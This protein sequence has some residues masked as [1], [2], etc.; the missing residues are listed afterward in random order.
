VNGMDLIREQISAVEKRIKRLGERSQEIGQIVSLISTMSE[1]THAL[2]LNASM[3]AAMAG[4]A[5]RGFAVVAEEVQRLSESARTST[6]QIAQLVQNI[7]VE[8]NDT[9]HTMNKAIEQVVAGS[10]AAAE[11]GER[12]HDTQETTARLVDLVQQINAGA[13]AQESITDILRKRV[14]DIGVST[15]QTA[16]Q[17]EVQNRSADLL[18][19]SARHLVA[20]VSVFKLPA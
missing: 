12:M 8:T 16:K 17:V 2:A 4:D 10:Q 20:A 13:V 3:Q 19:S 5:G 7:Q 18:V 1:R 6:I 11:S 14:A 15:E 9:I